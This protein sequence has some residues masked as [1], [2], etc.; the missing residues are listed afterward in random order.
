MKKGFVIKVAYDDG[1]IR[2]FL[3]D[4]YGES[5]LR[6]VRMYTKKEAYASK[7]SAKQ[8]IARY[9]DEDRH[10]SKQANYEGRIYE[11]IE[12]NVES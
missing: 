9:I 1:E 12:V 6:N 3:K 5:E 4:G 10:W 8:A 11:A 7:K 2:F